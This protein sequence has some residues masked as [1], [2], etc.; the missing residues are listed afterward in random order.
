MKCSTEL[1]QKLYKSKHFHFEDKN[2]ILKKNVLTYKTKKKQNKKPKN[3]FIKLYIKRGMG[4]TICY[5]LKGFV[6]LRYQ[7][8]EEGLRIG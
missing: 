1:T 6:Y 5:V 3:L 4:G 8:L 7:V 2:L